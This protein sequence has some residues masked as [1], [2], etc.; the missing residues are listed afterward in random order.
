MQC[1]ACGNTMTEVKTGDITVDACKGGCGSLWFDHFELRK[2]EQ[3]AQSAG[4]SLLNIPQNPKAKVD[5][6]QR[7]KCPR[8]ADIV[9]MRHFWSVQREATVDECPKCE[10]VF[11][12]PG[13]LAEIRG[14]YKTDADR[15]KAAREYYREMFDT[16]LA[17]VLARRL[18]PVEIGRAHV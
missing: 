18:V 1:P 12:D 11:L 3:P 9:M 10:G 7:R 16:Q 15:H 14:E 4:E 2:V 6:S 5:Q 17:V 13:E 8:D